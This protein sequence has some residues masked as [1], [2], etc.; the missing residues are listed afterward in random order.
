MS[1]VQVENLL[2]MV[3][4]AMPGSNGLD[5]AVEKVRRQLQILDPELAAQR[6]G[7]LDRAAHLAALQFENAEVLHPHSVISK[8]PQWYF[9]PEPG[10]I[11]WPALKTYLADVK[12]WP[13]TDV[14]SIDQASSEVVSL[15]ESP[16][17]SN[18]FQCRGLVVG[19]VQSG[20][21]ANMT[22]VIAKA[23]DSGYNTVIVLAGLTN[24]L[25]HQTQLRLASDLVQRNPMRWQVLTPDDVDRDFRAPPSG[26]F[27][28]HT[29]KAQIAIVKKNVSPLGELTKAVEATI[30]LALSRLRVLVIDDECDQASVNT[31]RQELDMTAIN[32]RIRELVSVIPAVSYVGYT[33]TP[34]ANV[35]IN[36]YRTEGQELDDLYPRDFIA[37]LPKPE[38]YFGTEQLFGREPTDAGALELEDEGLDMVRE[39]SE[40][41]E[42]KLQPYRR[43][44][45]PGFQPSM[46]ESLEDA[47]M[48]F[49]CCCAVRRARGHA[50]EHMTMLV[51]TSVYQVMHQRLARLIRRWKDQNRSLLLDRRSD[52]HKRMKRLWS[53]E[54]GRIPDDVTT[55]PTVTFA[56]MREHLP[57]VLEEIEVAVENGSSLDRIDYMSGPRTYIVVGGSILARG[58]TLEG[59]MVSF[60]LRSSTQY[61]TLLQMGRWFGYRAEYEDLPRIWTT[62]ESRVRFRALAGVEEE[63]RDEISQYGKQGLTPLDVAVRIR[64]VP[65][66]AITAASKMRNARRCSVS[67]WGV[68]RQTLRFKYLDSAWLGD[69]WRAAEELV[70]QADKLGCRDVDFDGKLWRDVPKSIMLRFFESYRAHESHEDLAEGFLLSFLRGEDS[71]LDAWNVGIVEPQGGAEADHPLGSAGVVRTV[72]RARLKGT[73]TVA[74]IKALMS[75]RDVMFDCPTESAEGTWEDLKSAR[76]LEVGDVPLLLLYVIDKTSTPATNSRVRTALGAADDVI[77]YGIVFPGSVADGG[78]YVS[79]EIRPLSADELDEID[80]AEQAQA[81]AAGVD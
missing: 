33:A 25:R 20:K 43:D 6:A 49:V 63:V 45:V 75:R 34:F 69:N 81:M 38:S 29:D 31:A 62:E 8:R 10:D 18:Q 3:L 68:H 60:F 39:V 79:V 76:A 64:A 40:E 50:D 1:S 57:A 46:V 21:T 22:A 12:G 35:L 5:A 61:D 72:R 13:A 58:L 32:Q 44:D 53:S 36:P 71:R 52:L 73:G 78:D 17:S 67:F 15:I 7:D 23:L 37:A 56:N 14:N 66:M 24:K 74:D 41:E 55:V 26:G 4:N 28:S 30:P 47:I 16:T 9:G 77:G 2:E 11:H 51:H 54:E 48:Y 27:L 59:L 42:A 80:A 19:H 65:G 70:D